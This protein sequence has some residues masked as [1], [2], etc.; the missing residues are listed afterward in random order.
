ML[1]TLLIDNFDSFTYNLSDLIHRVNGRAPHVVTNDTPWSDIDL[2]AYD[3][4]VVSP[5]PGR[6]QRESD[7]GIS[8][9]ALK[10]TAVPVL[11]IC[12]GHQGISHL[13]GGRV[14]HAP[15]PMH[16][17]VCEVHHS[18]S[19][20]FDGI[21]SPFKTVR[22]HSLA[23]TD[24]PAELEPLAWTA[25][26]VV[27]GVRSLRAPQ[28]GVQ[29]H[30]ESILTENGAKLL[31]NFRALVEAAGPGRT[32]ASVADRGRPRYR[33]ECRQVNAHPDTQSLFVDLYSDARYAFWLDSSR[34]DTA[35]SRF[36]FMGDDS[37]PLAEHL[38]YSV[39]EQAWSITCGVGTTRVEAPFFDYLNE[40]LA[41]RRVAHPP[42]L[43]FDFNLG[44]VGALG[45]ELK[46]ETGGRSRHVSP[47]PDGQLLFADRAIAV[48]HQEQCTYLLALVDTHAPD[49]VPSAAEWLDR[50][51]PAV[52][53]HSAAP[54][55]SAGAGPTEPRGDRA[56]EPPRFR[57]DQPRAEYLDS[58]ASCLD[59]ITDGESYEICLTNTAEAASLDAP[60]EA[61]LRLRSTSPVPFGA[62]LRA[63]PTA[64][65]SAS[66][67]RF[68]EVRGD[69]R[70]QAKPIKGTRPR[71]ATPEADAELSH[72]LAHNPKDR[73]EN[74]MIVDLLRN[75]LN[76][77]C[78]VG[79][80]RV[81]KLFD[82][83][84][85]SHV[86]QLVSTVEGRLA[87]GLTAVDCIRSAFPGGS[88][89]G[90]P[91]IRTMEI[92]DDLERRAR[93]YYSGAVGW[94]SLSGAADLSIV[95]RTVVNSEHS[96]TFGVG[97]AIVAL[98]DPEEEFTET[99]VKSRAM[100]SA[101]GAS[102]EEH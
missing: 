39:T 94:I 71:G 54:E 25:D 10:Q 23:A 27:M 53:R 48:D 26:G 36:T 92:I 11:G 58:I 17:R 86:H 79:S 85:Y 44:Y 88:M 47:L 2:D 15:E 72:E 37:G 77:V 59:A 21:P 12:L 9:L 67:E 46:A 80:V 52:H 100:V 70:V 98:S 76:R 101:L 32:A 97:G 65:L 24:L 68:L 45:Y 19:D 3:C 81:P 87:P 73:A 99:L 34:T 28:W 61:Y 29:F 75:D 35:F 63:G 43:P 62:Y 82:I 30:P 40:Q 102:I 31:D 5:G 55:P 7:L 18:G 84:T 16:G 66:P 90:A 4:V 1:R 49:T 60:L 33:I 42:E 51:V 22:Y 78:T 8:A 57:F 89:T 13:H 14:G 50:T 41:L 91:K 56:A 95:I 38:A 69:G 64:V 20:L 74:L 83:E 96:C 6:P 93:G